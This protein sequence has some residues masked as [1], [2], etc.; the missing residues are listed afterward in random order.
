MSAYC[1]VVWLNSFIGFCKDVRLAWVSLPF[2]SGNYKIAGANNMPPFKGV[3]PSMPVHIV[4]APFALFVTRNVRPTEITD[5]LSFKE[6]SFKFTFFK[7]FS[8]IIWVVAI[9]KPLGCLNNH[10]NFSILCHV[11]TLLVWPHNKLV[12]PTA[13]SVACF[14]CQRRGAASSVAAA[15]YPWR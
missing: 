12:E 1:S 3:Y 8:P 9:L 13:G 4:S 15:G 14:I 2:N 11:F 7:N 5:Y 10:W 6:L